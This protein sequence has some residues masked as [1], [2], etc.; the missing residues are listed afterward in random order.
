M[1][2]ILEFKKF[3]RKTMP[4]DGQL[5]LWYFPP[6]AG[7]RKFEVVKWYKHKYEALDGEFWASLNEDDMHWLNLPSE[8]ELLKEAQEIFPMDE[9][10]IET[11]RNDWVQAYWMGMC[12]IR[13]KILNQLKGG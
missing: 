13:N 7:W 3:T 10:E 12:Y 1:R 6:E 2:K 8:D 5:I 4:S 9:W 11:E